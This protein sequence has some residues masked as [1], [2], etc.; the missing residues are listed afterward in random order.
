MHFRSLSANLTA[1]AELVRNLT[2]GVLSAA[3][4]VAM[5]HEQLAS[6][7]EA[8]RRQQIH[9]DNL[10][11]A[12]VSSL[13]DYG[14]PTDLYACP[15]CG[16]ADVLINHARQRYVHVVTH[17]TRYRSPTAGCSVAGSIGS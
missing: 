7:Q 16:S 11:A 17:A 12:Q 4:L 8:Q 5:N 10:L 15:S 14:M 2:S 13:D 9:R 6:E 3:E 1:N